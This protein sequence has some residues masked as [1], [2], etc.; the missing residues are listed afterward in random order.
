MK[1]NSSAALEKRIHSLEWS[2]RVALTGL[3]L[4]ILWFTFAGRSA[5]SAKTDQDVKSSLRVR[6]L[7]V[8]DERGTARVRIAA[9]LPSPIIHGRRATRDDSI[10]GI[11]IYDHDGDERGGYVTDNSVGNAFLTL[12]S[13][14]TQDM[15]LV[16][17]PKEGAEFGLQ[18]N[19]KAEVAISARETATIKLIQNGKPV[20]RAPTQ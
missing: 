1:E 3:I 4:V 18:N 15:T 16:A 17:Y 20:F 13:K 19:K 7:V 10:A 9:P 11:L 5:V 8:V 6:E 2:N 14:S 12:D